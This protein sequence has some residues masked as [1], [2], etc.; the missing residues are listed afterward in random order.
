MIRRLNMCK[1]WTRGEYILQWAGKTYRT[2]PKIVN[3]KCI[4]F[5][6]LCYVSPNFA[7]RANF[8]EVLSKKFKEEIFY[9]EWLKIFYYRQSF[10]SSAKIPNFSRLRRLSALQAIL[11][12][13]DKKSTKMFNFFVKN[14]NI[15]ARAFGAR[16]YF[17]SEI[18]KNVKILLKISKK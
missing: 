15:F 8:K 13:L 9:W 1:R 12:N 10:S 18:V 7:R 2:K 4:Y 17:S 5:Q 11:V 6:S 3:K 14:T 16:K